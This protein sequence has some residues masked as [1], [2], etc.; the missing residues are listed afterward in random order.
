MKKYI[1]AIAVGAISAIFAVGLFNYI[2]DPFAYFRKPTWY[3]HALTGQQRA[4][5]AGIARSYEFDSLIIGSSAASNLK[6]SQAEQLFGGKF[7]KV[8]IFGA[9]PYQTAAA[10]EAAL[11]SRPLKN[12]F[13][14]VDPFYWLQPAA[15]RDESF[16]DYLYQPLSLELF[17]KYLLSIQTVRVSAVEL[18]TST[19]QSEP[20]N[21]DEYSTWISRCRANCNPGCETVKRFVSEWVKPDSASNR[22]KVSQTNFDI[23]RRAIVDQIE[24]YLLPIVRAYPQTKF[25]FFVPPTSSAEQLTIAVNDPA[26]TLQ[27]DSLKRRMMEISGAEPNVSF[28]DFNELQEITDDLN[29][30]YDWQHYTATVGERMM[31]IM[32]KSDGLPTSPDQ[33]DQI[34]GRTYASVFKQCLK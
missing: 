21:F 6:P 4:V 11:R 24:L 7:S 3:E 17:R 12:V 23:Y 5:A 2:V 33:L 15:T 26:A 14:T 19:R 20:V 13:V 1:I 29:F 30:Y 8:T 27:R 22:E 25:K 10:L 34:F 16:P 18:A 9:R 31:E 32:A 28:Y